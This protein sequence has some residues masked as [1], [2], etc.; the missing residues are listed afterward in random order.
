MPTYDWWWT[1]GPP[2]ASAIAAIG[3]F[4]FAGAIWWVYVRQLQAMREQAKH[5]A[6]GLAAAKLSADVARQTLLIVNRP[7]LALRPLEVDGILGRH[8]ADRLQNGFVVVTNT[9]VFPL[10]LQKFWAQ[11]MFADALPVINPARRAMDNVTPATHVAPGAFGKCKLPDYELPFEAFTTINNAADLA[12]KA[13]SAPYAPGTP[14]GRGGSLYLC[15]YIKY[16]DEIGLRRT[17][18]LYRYDPMR[19]LFEPFEHPNY[20]YEE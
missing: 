4:L 2:L 9:G 7:K 8:I 5:M 15:G 10:V 18:F 12:D 20:S 1:L 19:G 13:I 16:S 14:P 17:Y 3:S 11:W 6:D